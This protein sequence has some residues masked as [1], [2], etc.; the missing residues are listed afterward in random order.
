[1]RKRISILIILLLCFCFSP[2]YSDSTFCNKECLQQGLTHDFCHTFCAPGGG[3]NNSGDYGP[4]QPPT[5]QECGKMWERCLKSEKAEKAQCDQ[6]KKA[7]N[8]N[9]NK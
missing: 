4:P 5:P 7:C 1:M 3:S 2:A 6:L 8:N 9:W